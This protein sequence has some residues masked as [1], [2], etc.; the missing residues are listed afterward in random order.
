[1]SKTNQ[2]K[3]KKKKKKKKAGQWIPLFTSS[4]VSITRASAHVNQPGKTGAAIFL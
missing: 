1:M 3:R 2:K 4:Q